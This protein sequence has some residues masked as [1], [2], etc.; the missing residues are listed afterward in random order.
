MQEFYQNVNKFDAYIKKNESE[1]NTNGVVNGTN[2][3]QNN[4]INGFNVNNNV[5]N[6]QFSNMNGQQVVSN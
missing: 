4:Q 3:N 1:N 2:V 5:I 6:N